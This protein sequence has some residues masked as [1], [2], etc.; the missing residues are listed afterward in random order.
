MALLLLA[1]VLDTRESETEQAAA[2][3]GSIFAS[4]FVQYIFQHILIRLESTPLA[5]LYTFLEAGRQGKEHGG[6]E[7]KLGIG[8]TGLETTLAL[9]VEE[10]GSNN[11]RTST[12]H[13]SHALHLLLHDWSE[14][15]DSGIASMTTRSEAVFAVTVAVF[16]C[17]TVFVFFRILS[18]VWIV[19]RVSLDDYF[20][21]LAWV[22][23]TSR[24]FE[25]N[26]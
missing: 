15:A 17:S 23:N 3:A 2:V 22:R 1:S 16:A 7:Y 13:T 6:L 20:M 25:T 8:R 11:Y 4:C 21:L 24:V 14:M 26:R 10:H 19:R 5:S 12:P 9:L 18:R